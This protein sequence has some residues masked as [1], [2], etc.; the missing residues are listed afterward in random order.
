LKYF[1]VPSEHRGLTKQRNYGVERV[2][3]EMEVVCFLDDD[4]VLE[5]DYF[6]ELIKHSLRTLIF[7]SRW[8]SCK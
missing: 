4:T 8:S 1:L 2:G 7:Q 5:I 6:E 3:D